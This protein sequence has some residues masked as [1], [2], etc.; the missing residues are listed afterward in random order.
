LRAGRLLL[1]LVEVTGDQLVDRGAQ[2]TSVRDRV[3]TGFSSQLTGR[4]R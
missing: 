2:S 3:T 1:E 4:G